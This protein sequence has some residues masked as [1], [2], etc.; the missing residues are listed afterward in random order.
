MVNS[1]PNVE[2]CVPIN[3]QNFTDIE[4][5]QG[6]FNWDP[7][8]L[9]Y[10]G[11]NNNQ[12]PGMTLVENNVSTGILTF[13]WF[14]NTGTSP[15]SLA[16]NSTLLELCFN[17][18]GTVG[19]MSPVSLTNN[20]LAV[21]F[22]DGSVVDPVVINNGKVTIIDMEVDPVQLIAANTSGDQGSNTCVDF[23][24]KNFINVNGFEANIVYNNAIVDFT[25]VTNFGLPGLIAGNFSEPN[26]NTVRVSWNT[27]NGDSIDA[28]DDTV[29]F[30]LCFD[31][32]GSC[33]TQPQ[34]VSPID[35]QDLEVNNGSV[36]VESIGVDGTLAVNPCEAECN[37][38]ST[39]NITC[40]GQ[41][42]G[43]IIVS[44][45]VP[46]TDC[47]CLWTLPSGSVIERDLAN[48]NLVG[49]PAGKYTLDVQCGGVS[50]CTQM[51]T[52]TEPAQLTASGTKVNPACDDDG[53]INLS[54]SGGT[55]MYTITWAPVGVIADGTTN[56]TGLA[57]G[58]Y[59]A[60]INDA[61]GCGP[62]T[63]EF[64]LVR[65]IEDLTV[66]IDKTNVKCFGQ[67]N[68]TIT[69]N[70]SGACAP[71]DVVWS[72]S[73]P[74]LN[75]VAP[76]TYNVTVTGKNN[77]T[78]MGSVT[79]T[80]PAAALSAAPDATG[81]MAGANEGTINLNIQGGTPPYAT[82]WTTSATP[83]A[84]G[85]L[86]AT[87]LNPGSY[88]VNVT[89]ANGCTLTVPNIMVNVVTDI[90]ISL[91]SVAVTSESSF[92]G[93]GVSCF[94]DKNGT[95]KGTISNGTPPF[96]IKLAGVETFTVM[97]NAGNMFTINNL[98]AGSYNLS[99]TNNVAPDAYIHPTPIVVTQPSVIDINLVNE[100]LEGCDNTPECDGY[101]D[102]EVS[103]GT[104]S[105][106]YEWSD[107]DFADSPSVDNLCE[108][109]YTVLVTDENDC[110]VM[111]SNIEVESCDGPTNDGCFEADQVITP[112]GDGRNEL[113]K[114]SCIN[115]APNVLTIYDR[116]G[117]IVYT[118]QNYNNTWNG[119]NASGEELPENGYMWV[120]EVD[121]NSGTPRLITGT[122]TLLRN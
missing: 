105:Y 120:L 71:Y 25:N 94:G 58:T 100:G 26:N 111:M 49:V 51:V 64:I 78:K 76:G 62:I 61:N 108:G 31:V 99:I 30:S 1:L 35:I 102:I 73:V 97:V 60:T 69:L 16:D 42:T 34:L 121:Y 48:C 88:T 8:V 9:E 33:E 50:E 14:D 103:G 107:P 109:L 118:E 68:G 29:I 55:P 65:N 22:N 98:P 17:V 63:R 28:D 74:D 85:V 110:E 59:T 6:S 4:A 101:I 81:S 39:K 92:N 119:V 113:F 80:Q 54:V 41:S 89:D 122:V 79:I 75:N 13:I 90:A 72:P 52:L 87:G 57:P 116:W 7:A 53:S 36:A 20:T 19:Q 37:I 2:V 47:K 32:N 27:N 91:A 95:V 45:D 104:G 70:I 12:L 15:V 83:V 77:T 117:K 93:F 86:E 84:N 82:V 3:V 23:T 112:N 44:I 24:V 18:I 115:I 38:V 46:G 5:A 106:S 10:V 96:T 56:P 21:E 67:T 43:N 11:V 40:F 66:S 114:I